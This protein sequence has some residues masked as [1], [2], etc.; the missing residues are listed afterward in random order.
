MTWTKRWGYEVRPTKTTGVMIVRDGRYLVHGKVSQDGR[1]R[2]IAKVI[3]APSVRDAARVR[4]EML[5]GERERPQNSMPL[6]SAYGP[7]LYER[8]VAQRDLKSAKTRERW[9]TTLRLHLLPAFGRFAVDALTKP[10]IETWK[11]RLAK[12]IGDGKLSPR[13][14]NGWLSILRVIVRSAVDDF[15]LERDPTLRVRDFSVEEHPTYT[16]E[17][18]NSLTREQTA[19][20]LAGMRRLFPQFYAVTLLGFVTGLRPSTLRPL[21]RR[22]KEADVLW[23]HSAILVRRSNSIGQEV[24]NTTKTGTTYRLGLPKEVMAVLTAHVASLHGVRKRSDLLFPSKRAGIMS[25]SALDKPFA[26]VSDAIGLPFTL[27]PR[28]MRR[29]YQDLGRELGV[30]RNVRKAIC[31]HAT[32][33]MSDLYSTVRPEEMALAVGRITRAVT[34]KKAA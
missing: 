2:T 25:R 21:R 18:P 6:F 14:A 17:K 1:K 8:K 15:G 19:R 16:D 22:G 23:E 32:D 26:S 7:S 27:T 33:E 28:G 11:T 31:G 4:L 29:T 20:F 3:E 24:M 30:E 10:D 12:Q 9:D 34:R 5:G 13:T